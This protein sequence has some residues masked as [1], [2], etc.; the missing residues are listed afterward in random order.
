MA[1]VPTIT[2]C[3]SADMDDVL[4]KR[5]ATALSDGQPHEA[6]QLAA[7]LG[8]SHSLMAWA[9]A[10]LQMAGEVEYVPTWPRQEWWYRAVQL[11][12]L[13]SGL[14]DEPVEMPEG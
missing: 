3:W 8:V 11:P 4:I 1:T 9:L 14:L 2:A 13:S 10:V 5:V 7:D 12:R 6:R